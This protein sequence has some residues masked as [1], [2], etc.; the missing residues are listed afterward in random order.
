[1][2]A[3]YSGVIATRTG[4]RHEAACPAACCVGEPRRD[5]TRMEAVG[6]DAGSGEAARDLSNEQEFGEL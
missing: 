6:G 3:P 5:E 2:S 4:E 1:V